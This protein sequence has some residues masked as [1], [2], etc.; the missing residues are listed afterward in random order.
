MFNALKNFQTV[1]E[2]L[3][4]CYISISSMAAP[5]STY[6]PMH[7]LFSL[8]NFDHPSGYEVVSHCWFDLHFPS[9]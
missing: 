8:F 3:Q 2:R 5:I 1:P 9:D 4:N 7:L 6:P